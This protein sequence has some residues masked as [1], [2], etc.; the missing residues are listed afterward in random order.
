MRKAIET[1]DKGLEKTRNEFISEISV[2]GH[3]FHI[4]TDEYF[5]D[6]FED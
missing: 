6:G 1:Y 4:V 5:D 2:L 3:K